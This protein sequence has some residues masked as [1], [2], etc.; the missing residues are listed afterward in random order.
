MLTEAN[1]LSEVTPPAITPT[2][3]LL[4]WGDVWDDF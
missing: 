1:Q 3:A 4:P 2:I